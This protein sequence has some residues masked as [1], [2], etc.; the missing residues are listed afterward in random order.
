MMQTLNNYAQPIDVMI[1]H[2]P[3]TVALVWGA[4]RGLV[5][6]GVCACVK[7]DFETLIRLKIA[8]KHAEISEDITNGLAECLRMSGICAQYL[9]RSSISPRVRY[10]IAEYYAGVLNLCVR[11]TIFY[12]KPTICK[13]FLTQ[14]GHHHSGGNI[15]VARCA[16]SGFTPAQMKFRGVL[17]KVRNLASQLDQEGLLEMGQSR[18][19]ILNTV[20]KQVNEDFQQHCPLRP[21]S[22]HVQ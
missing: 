21:V 5:V 18:S 16:I 4:I 7:K 8:V 22:P 1:Q 15:A 3:D 9:Q 19:C 12:S 10:A 13:S 2:H 20:V 6:V 14:D 11:A 17:Q